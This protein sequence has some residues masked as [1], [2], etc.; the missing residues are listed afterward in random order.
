MVYVSLG[1]CKQ[2]SVMSE[3]IILRHCTHRVS[4]QRTS[5]I[6]KAYEK[7]ERLLANY[8]ITGKDSCVHAV[9]T[10]EAAAVASVVVVACCMDVSIYTVSPVYDAVGSLLVVSLL[11]TIASFIIY[12]TVAA[13]VGRSTKP[14]IRLRPFT[15]TLDILNAPT[16]DWN[17]GKAKHISVKYTTNKH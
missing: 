3:I 7:T 6:I 16:A 8:V 9:L 2:L 4:C 12:T 11:G 1:E 5:S 17:V 14:N 13:L 10:E 15:T